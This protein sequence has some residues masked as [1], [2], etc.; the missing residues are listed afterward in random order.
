MYGLVFIIAILWIG[1]LLPRL[2]G[3]HRGGDIPVELQD[4]PH[5]YIAEG[6]VG[7]DNVLVV[8]G[9]GE[10]V[11]FER[12]GKTYWEAY[13]CRFEDCPGRSPEGQDLVFPHIVRYIDA[14]GNVIEHDEMDAPDSMAAPE[15]P[16]MIEY[17]QP[18]LCPACTINDIGG[19]E[20]IER[21]YTEEGKERLRK[22]RERYAKKR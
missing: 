5:T 10:K 16:M 13:V 4:F 1:W 7:V 9:K 15:D 19:S 3:C 12:D 18:A 21:Y 11:P 6:E 14:E 8:S 22:L 2:G 20:Y 17:M